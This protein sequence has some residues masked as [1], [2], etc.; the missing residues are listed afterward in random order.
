MSLCLLALC[1]ML[2]PLSQP[3]MS[4][5]CALPAPYATLLPLLP[6][7]CTSLS[8][9]CHI[10][11]PLPAICIMSP[12]LSQP[13]A[14]YCHPSHSCTHHIAVPSQLHTPHCHALSAAH[15]TLSPSCSHTPLS[16]MHYIA[17]PLPAVHTIL[18][19]PSQLY[20]PHCHTS[21]SCVHHVAAP[22]L[23]A[24]ATSP[25]PS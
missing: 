2:P 1:A 16:P 9:T 4:H 6:C 20:V 19:H 14:P 23:A 7:R 12:C 10:A 18:L 8:P 11:A 24:H 22:L 5:C 17:M 3:H 13:H 21:P 25:C 15:T